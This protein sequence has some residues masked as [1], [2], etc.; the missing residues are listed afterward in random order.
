MNNEQ[1]VAENF[2][3]FVLEKWRVS[4]GEHI[5]EAYSFKDYPFLVDIA[6][7]TF[8]FTVV[9]KSAQV[10]ISEL[11]VARA[12]W[13]AI[14][15]PG[16]ILY[17][18]PAGEQMQQFVDA[19]VR[20]PIENNPFL[21][22]F[23]SG[24]FN[25]KKIKIG[26]NNLYFRGAQKR[27][28]MI[29]VDA[30]VHFGDE[31]DEY[32]E[33]VLY[34]LSKRLG[35]SKHPIK[36]YFS[37]PTFHST[38]ISLYYAGSETM[39]Q[40]GSDQR[41]WGLRCSHCHK[42][43]EGLKWPDNIR[44]DNASQASSIYYKPDVHLICK[45]CSGILHLGEDKAEWITSFKTNSDYC[46]GYALSKLISPIADL[47]QMYL[48]SQ[49]P[50]KEQEFFNSDLGEPYEPKGSRL[51]DTAIM[52]CRGNYLTKLKCDEAC[53]VGI[54]I[55]LKIHVIVSIEDTESRKP[56][57]IAA[58]ELDEWEDLD[59]VWKNFNVAGCVIDAN[60]DKEEAIDFQSTHENLWLAYYMQYLE[61]TSDQI[62]P[63]WDEEIVHIH[64]TLMM[65]ITMSLF[66]DRN[67]ILP[68]D[69]MQ[70]RDFSDHMKSPVRALKQTL[71]GD[72]VPFYPK[73]RN[74][75]HFFHATV[76]N[77][78]AHKL[79]SAPAVYKNVKII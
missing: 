57:I 27:R 68:I 59:Q 12:I 62:I 30:S 16:N 74:P 21:Y 23:I 67:V 71:Q 20:T 72:W 8:P 52:S 60:P 66:N 42:W 38:G 76:Y 63:K 10:G 7:D 31:I 4:S 9:K 50:L 70:V 18:F 24:S 35:A 14:F 5:G 37:T 17:S 61:K 47:N 65:E 46:H 44:D 56:K 6:K 25:L 48:D 22:D 43:N 58:L 41:V 69:I 2:L 13:R 32:E 64:R 54:D 53:Y 1:L 77:F 73:T 34:T 51:T 49:D 11:Q 3:I 39:G 29:T 26:R 45:H 19:R 78:V 55:G 79:K 40:R 28:Q 75:D 36:H 15:K 33:G